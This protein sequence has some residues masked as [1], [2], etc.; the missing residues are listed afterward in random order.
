MRELAIFRGHA[1]S[2][3]LGF[4]SAQLLIAQQPARPDPAAPSLVIIVSGWP[5]YHYPGC[6]RLD[7]MTENLLAVSVGQATARGLKPHDACDPS[8]ARPAETLKTPPKSRKAPAKAG[9]LP[10]AA[11]VYILRD[12]RRYHQA[13]C[14]KMGLG[15]RAIRLDLLAPRYVPCPVC[16]PPARKRT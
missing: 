11:Y 7:G 1:L 5:D 14:P 12:D 15:A 10:G 16:K 2:L 8:R 6:R 4:A 13:S 3:L 9:P